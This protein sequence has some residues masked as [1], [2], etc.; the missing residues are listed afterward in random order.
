MTDV[1][2]WKFL[3]VFALCQGDLGVSMQTK[4]LVSMFIPR[5]YTSPVCL[6]K[7]TTRPKH[8]CGSRRIR[9]L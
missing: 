6:R 2:S 3:F 1:Q 5:C 4:G 9:S 8:L 7:G